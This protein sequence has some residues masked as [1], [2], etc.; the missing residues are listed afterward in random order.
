M[1]TLKY[2]SNN[3]NICV[4]LVLTIFWLFFLIQFE[5]FLVLG[6]TSNFIWTFE[7][8]VRLDFI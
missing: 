4:I 3:S 2:F 6:E 7:S 5:I 8:I 1:G